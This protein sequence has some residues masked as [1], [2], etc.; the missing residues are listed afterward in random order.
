MA[1]TYSGTLSHTMRHGAGRTRFA[2]SY[3]SYEG[4]YQDG[5]RHGQ[6]RLVLGDVEDPDVVI[7]G[8]FLRGE[9]NGW[10]RKMWKDGRLYTGEFVDGEPSGQGTLHAPGG[11]GG[12]RYEG[13]FLSGRFH[14]AQGRLTWT[15]TTADAA[16]SIRCVYEGDFD[17]N[18][19][20]GH[21]RLERAWPGHGGSNA[22]GEGEGAQE[23]GRGEE[24]EQ[25]ENGEEHDDFAEVGD[26]DADTAAAASSSSAGGAEGVSSSSSSHPHGS[27]FASPPP[28]PGGFLVAYEGGFANNEPHGEGTAE[29]AD[30]SLYVGS[31]A[32]GKRNGQ[33]RLSYPSTSLPPHDDDSGAAQGG[34][35]RTGASSGAPG[36]PT[37]E[38]EWKDDLPAV[39]PAR[40]G[41]SVDAWRKPTTATWPPAPIRPQTAGSTVEGGTGRPGTGKAAGAAKAPAAAA[42]AKKGSAAGDAAAAV[43]AHE[44]APPTPLHRPGAVLAVPGEPV[45]G[46]C[47]TVLAASAV[48]A[49]VPGAA[50][51]AAAPSSSSGDGAEGALPSHVDEAAAAQQHSSSSDAGGSSS[52]GGA[53]PHAA[54]ILSHPL[55]LAPGEA[56]VSVESGRRVTVSLLRHET[57]LTHFSRHLILSRDAQERAAAK[58]AAE[59]EAA[60]AAAAAGA[61]AGA[62]G[63][64]AKAGGGTS[65]PGT[66]AA[67]AEAIPTFPAPESYP[68]TIEPEASAQAVPLAEA[69]AGQEDVLPPLALSAATVEGVVRLGGRLLLPA[70]TPPGQYTLV[71]RDTTPLQPYGSALGAAYVAVDVLPA[72]AFQAWGGGGVG[73]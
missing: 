69:G 53:H 51:D 54:V 67:P 48:A 68:A 61:K 19:R 62:K 70:S 35:E 25:P 24:R 11:A 23:E 17:G 39:L 43:P 34:D 30:G 21:G 27:P 18:R 29:Y 12:L 6:G 55:V 26:A 9:L 8:R 13:P 3:F 36:G 15:A 45:P 58:A 63:P 28:V 7:E 14:G 65:K 64:A 71:V 16:V 32:G 52:D 33:G 41:V 57:A 38:G 59:L 73:E 40:L 20:H 66:A 1:S 22:E 50:A 37:Y 2:N 42:P 46:I 4:Q 31:F 10:G 5:L 72:A 60:A 49:G 44:A 56:P 47:I